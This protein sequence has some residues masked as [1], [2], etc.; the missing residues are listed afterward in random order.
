M[1]TSLS[2]APGTSAPHLG[3]PAGRPRVPAKRRSGAAARRNRWV[4][5]AFMSPWVIGFGVFFAYPLLATVFYSF[6]SYDLINEPVFV[7]I[8]NYVFMFTQDPLIWVSIRNTVYLVVAITV[9]RV[10]YGLLT[11]MVLTKIKRG[12]GVFRTLFY[13][14]AL[15]PPVAA[16]LAFVFLFNPGTGPVNQFLAVF[17]IKGPLWFND[18][19]LAKPALTVLALW[20]SGEIMVILLA[21][22]L[23]VPADYYEAAALDGAGAFTRFWHITLPSISPVLLFAIINS[24]IV[25]LQ[26]FTEAVV[27]GAVASGSSDAVG[28][29][30]S[31]GYPDNSTLTFPMWLYEQGFHS[32]NMGYASTMAIVLFIVS[33]AFTI[34][35]VRRMRVSGV[36][37]ED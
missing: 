12:S 19:A 23:D 18:P 28:N 2:A 1:T 15:A 11:A 26:Y 8:Q 22:L 27:A 30:A 10:V 33:A 32:Y 24:I 14:P 4:V 17:G 34:I 7:G 35:L 21:A 16:A 25:G 37:E 6:T 9:G 3:A 5:L 29:I 13:L 20:A 36:G 31:L